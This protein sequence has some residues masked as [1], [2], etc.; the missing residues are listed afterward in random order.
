MKN[1]F[2]GLSEAGGEKNKKFDRDFLYEFFFDGSFLGER[3][4]NKFFRVNSE[5]EKNKKYGDGKNKN[6]NGDFE[7]EKIGNKNFRRGSGE[8]GPDRKQRRQRPWMLGEAKHLR[9]LELL[10]EGRG[11]VWIANEL[12]VGVQTVQRR[13]AVLRREDDEEGTIDFRRVRGQVCEKHGALTVWPCVQC[14]A[15]GVMEESG[16]NDNQLWRWN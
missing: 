6:E 16:R 9:I 14:A 1:F 5:S 7:N 15:E 3:L 13:A 11:K 10:R 8:R 4:R 2:D 12:G